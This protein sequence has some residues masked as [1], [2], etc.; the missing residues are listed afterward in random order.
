MENKA[1][2][3][4]QPYF[5]TFSKYKIAGRRI[6]KQSQLLGKKYKGNHTSV[7]TLWTRQSAGFLYDLQLL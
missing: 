5:C 4:G 1:A 2:I 7:F 3:P 6:S